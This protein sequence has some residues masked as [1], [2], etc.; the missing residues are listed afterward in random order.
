MPTG[1]NHSGAGASSTRQSAGSSLSMTHAP[2]KRAIAT[3]PKYAPSA[4]ATSAST[5][6]FKASF[7]AVDE[8]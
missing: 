1:W 5:S 2:P 4:G 6:G 3:C 7:F 8:M